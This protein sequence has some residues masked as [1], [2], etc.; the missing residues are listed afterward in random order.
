[1]RHRPSARLLARVF[2]QL[3]NQVLRPPRPM[4]SLK[5]SFS[6]RRA[7]LPG[8]H[9]R[10][11]CSD[12]KQS[13]QNIQ[14]FVV[15]PLRDSG[16][17]VTVFIATYHD[18]SCPARDQELLDAYMPTAFQFDTDPYTS[19]APSRR[20]DGY[21][22]ALELVQ[23]TVNTTSVDVDAIVMLRF[24]VGYKVPITAL[25]VDW[26]QTNLP[27]RD[28]VMQWQWCQQVSDLLFVFPIAH[29][30]PMIRALGMSFSWSQLA[31]GSWC[32]MPAN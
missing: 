19:T 21:I 16:V 10:T 5:S 7:K 27:F 4:N 28:N 11:S 8:M 29:V 3:Q 1:M 25:P 22:H 32:E 18:T 23:R 12:W 9:G 17:E 14:D 26:R 6:Y 2:C 15:Q 13:Y 31:E 20:V 30:G 24:D